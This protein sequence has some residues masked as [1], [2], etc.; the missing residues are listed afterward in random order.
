[1][2]SPADAPDGIHL[3]LRQRG[4]PRGHHKGDDGTVELQSLVSAYDNDGQMDPGGDKGLSPV[5]V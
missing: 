1:M 3:Q 2:D 4:R 5:F